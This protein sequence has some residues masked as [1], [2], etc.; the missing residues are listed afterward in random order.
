V[1]DWERYTADQGLVSTVG[2]FADLTGGSI[3]LDVWNVIGDADV[4]LLTGAIA[5]EP[6]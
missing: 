3:Q 2:D 1:F 4:T 6:I 5:S